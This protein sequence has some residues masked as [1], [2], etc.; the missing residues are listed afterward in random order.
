MGRI[1]HP[2]GLPPWR[3]QHKLRQIDVLYIIR[4]ATG[5]ELTEATLSPLERGIAD[6]SITTRAMRRTRGEKM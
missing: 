6:T 2:N 4:E 1:K 5:L 3:D